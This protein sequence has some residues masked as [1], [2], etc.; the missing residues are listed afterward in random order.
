MNQDDLM[1]LKVAIDTAQKARDK[2]N[3]PFGALLA[4]EQKNILLVAENTVVTEG[5]CTGHAETNL[6]REASTRFDSEFLAKCTL[7]TSTEPCPMCVGAI[8]WGNVRRIVY[9]LSTKSFY[10]LIPDTSDEVLQVPCQD[11]IGLGKKSI[12]VVGPALEKEA[13]KVHQ[14]FW[15]QPGQRPKN[16]TPKV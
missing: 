3:H 16:K 10:E 1:L 15:Q 4:D 14:G 5:D 9:A 2:G 8:F 6:M 13:L 11:L 7:Y 12:E